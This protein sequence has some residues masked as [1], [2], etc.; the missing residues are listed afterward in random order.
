[1]IIERVQFRPA[2]SGFKEDAPYFRIHVDTPRNATAAGDGENLRTISPALPFPSSQTRWISPQGQ[3]L[4]TVDNSLPARVGRRLWPAVVG[5]SPT[6]CA[7][8]ATW[9]S[10]KNDLPR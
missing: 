3:A 8:S 1:M 7:V 6:T 9:S 10:E 5:V 2:A 4:A